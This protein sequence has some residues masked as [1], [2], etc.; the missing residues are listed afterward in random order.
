M[1]RNDLRA[2]RRL[3]FVRW[4]QVENLGEVFD[5]NSL[6]RLGSIKASDG[7]SLT[8][9]FGQIVRQVTDLMS[10]HEP[11][12]RHFDADGGGQSHHRVFGFGHSLVTS[13]GQLRNPVP[14]NTA[15]WQRQPSG[16]FQDGREF[17]LYPGQGKTK[18]PISSAVALVPSIL[19]WWQGSTLPQMAFRKEIREKWWQSD[20]GRMHVLDEVAVATLEAEA[21]SGTVD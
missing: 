10:W 3:W 7:E 13:Q 8:E 6:S 11:N 9:C 20:A 14:T 2:C 17:Q 21:Q 12:L 16:R 15:D 18:R 4:I 5:V 19:A 1:A